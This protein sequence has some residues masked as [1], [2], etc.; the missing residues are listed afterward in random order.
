MEENEP[1]TK[2]RKL[3][4]AQTEFLHAKIQAAE[5]SD[6]LVIAKLQTKRTENKL[7]A[8]KAAL[9]AEETQKEFWKLVNQCFYDARSIPQQ[10][11]SQFDMEANCC[12]GCMAASATIRPFFDRNRESFDS[13][14]YLN[15]I[16]APSGTDP[17]WFD[18]A[19]DVCYD[20]IKILQYEHHAI[21]TLFYSHEL[22]QRTTSFPRDLINICFNYLYASHLSWP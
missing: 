14:A 21:Q 18:V 17:I 1:P 2:H 13:I 11:F 9:C 5:K 6:A 12:S 20:K 22:I 19:C 3:Q 4:V 8:C 10:R 7:W 16:A 15:G